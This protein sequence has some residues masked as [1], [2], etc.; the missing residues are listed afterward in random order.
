LD[1]PDDVIKP[2][3]TLY[4]HSGWIL[5]MKV[6]GDYLY[7]GSD[8]KTIIIWDLVRGEFWGFKLVMFLVKKVDHF[9]AHQD[10]ISCLNFANKYLYSGSYDSKIQMW[11]VVELLRKVKNREMMHVEDGWSMKFNIWYDLVHKKKRGRGRR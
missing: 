3:H 9:K 2:E 6:Q 11:D 1:E 8:D 5:D 7:T 4:G 10:S